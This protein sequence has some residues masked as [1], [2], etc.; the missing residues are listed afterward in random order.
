MV[1]HHSDRSGLPTGDRARLRFQLEH[2]SITEKSR[3]AAVSAAVRRSRPKT[4]G[5]KRDPYRP[6]P[7]AD[8]FIAHEMAAFAVRLNHLHHPM[9]RLVQA[10]SDAI[11]RCI[12]VEGDDHQPCGSMG[13]SRCRAKEASTAQDL[14]EIILRQDL[15][16][17]GRNRIRAAT[18]LLFAAPLDG[19][20][21]DP[22]GLANRVFEQ[23]QWIHG[24]AR[25]IGFNFLLL[26]EFKILEPLEVMRHSHHRA[27]VE[28]ILPDW[29]WSARVLVAHVHGLVVLPEG[30][31][32]QTLYGLRQVYPAPYS[33][34]LKGLHNNQS[35]EEAVSRWMEYAGEQEARHEIPV[36]ENQRLSKIYR[37][38]DLLLIDQIR[39]ELTKDVSIFEWL[40]HLP[41]D[42]DEWTWEEILEDLDSVSPRAQPRSTRRKIVYVVHYW[43]ADLT[44]SDWRRH[45]QGS[46]VVQPLRGCL[47][48][49]G[50]PRGEVVDAFYVGN[51]PSN[52]CNFT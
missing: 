18:I 41:K 42:P 28:A 5:R 51:G 12:A 15:T 19:Q 3:R 29:D 39:H 31:D 32:G 14:G 35:I 52:R 49:R 20:T 43:S 40:G 21:D 30:D 9:A 10:K 33:V 16:R 26:P 38:P 36:R 4:G 47:G 37:A 13:C 34:L 17:V 7:D 11:R 23:M 25:R 45:D 24:R 22:V 50:P 46:R 1:E 27:Y 48:P 6:Y 44:L 8:R 2:C